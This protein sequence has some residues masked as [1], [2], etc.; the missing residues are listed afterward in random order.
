VG[1]VGIGDLEHRQGVADRIHAGAA[2]LGRHL[3]AHQAVLTEHADVLQRE[4]AGTVE[5]GGGGRD[6]LLR[7][8]TGDVADHQLFFGEIEIHRVL[9]SNGRLKTGQV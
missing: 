4:L 2:V 5:F 7:D 6:A 8:A 9:C 3:D 1:A